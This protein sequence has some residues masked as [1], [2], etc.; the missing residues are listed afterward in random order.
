MENIKLG[1]PFFCPRCQCTHSSAITCDEIQT[2]RQRGEEFWANLRETTEEEKAILIRPLFT[3]TEEEVKMEEQ[4]IGAALLKY[5]ELYIANKQTS[6]ANDWKKAI[7]YCH[8]Q[9]NRIKQ[10]QDEN[11]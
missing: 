10:W 9:L 4:I 7:D 8:K 11:K 2:M 6:T 5:H 3:L 1:G